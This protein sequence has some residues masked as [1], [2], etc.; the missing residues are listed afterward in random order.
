MGITEIS[1]MAK[2]FNSFDYQGH[3]D[4]SLPL[5]HYTRLDTLKKILTEKKLRFTN[6]AYLNDKSEGIDVL[7][8]C[9]EH[10]DDVWTWGDEVDKRNTKEAFCECL[11]EA[12][13]DVKSV[14]WG[15][16]GNPFES[17]QMS[18]SYKPD[19]L[20]MW[21]Y[22]AK[23]GGCSLYFSSEL[24]EN[25]RSRLV[26]P[27]GMSLIFLYGKV[28][29]DDTLKIKILRDI[30]DYFKPYSRTGSVRT[31]YFCLID[32][33]LKMGAFFKHPGFE[34]ER[35]CRIVFN[36]RTNEGSDKFNQL[37]HPGDGKL[38]EREK[39]ES[40]GMKIPSVDIDFDIKH[41][42]HI[43]VAPT[44]DFGKTQPEIKNV[45][46]QQG[47]ENLFVDQSAIP[48]RF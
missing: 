13:K 2:A 10:I 43:M 23:D 34:D 29:Y 16:D 5:Y 20:M 46:I 38:Y 31:L 12:V 40:H 21:N 47:I 37:V 26:N 35:E 6:R 4:T 11:D 3:L 30:F 33:I 9:K 36:L 1:Q 41:L 19:S 24:I 42:Q 27:D 8:F 17:Y 28:I 22:Y 7:T 32:C 15:L 45:L 14:K 48:L 44:V 18:F 39:H 25:L